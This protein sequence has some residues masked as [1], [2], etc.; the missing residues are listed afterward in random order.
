MNVE[1]YQK[2]LQMMNQW[3]II[4]QE[5]RG[6]EEYFLLRNYK[7]IG[8]YGMAVYG[9]HLIRELNGSRIEVL[10]GIDQKELKPYKGVNI[11]HL[12]EKLPAVDAIINTVIQEHSYIKS[13]I[14][15]ICNCPIV[16]LEDVVFDSYE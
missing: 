11:Y 9:R 16:S 1:G 4:K 13:Q 2:Y 10:Y 6:L 12:S 14:E 15:N 3:L 8:I 7:K 5:G